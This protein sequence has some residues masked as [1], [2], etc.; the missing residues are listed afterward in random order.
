MKALVVEQ[1]DANSET[2]VLCE[3]RVGDSE[4]VQQ[5]QVV[6][7]V[8]TSKVVFELESPEAG[9]LVQGY[10]AGAEVRFNVP[11]GYIVGSPLEEKMA[12]AA[13]RMS[14]ERPE[15][16][17]Q[18]PKATKKARQLAAQYSVR[19]ED[20]QK[21]GL[22]TERDVQA[23]IA[24]RRKDAPE[25]DLVI[26]EP[27]VMPRGLPRVLVL[28]AGLGAMQVIDILLNDPR[29]QVVGCL[30]D[31]P[32]TH[33]RAIFGVQVWGA[34][35]LLEEAWREGQLDQAIISISTSAGARK[36]LYQR[37]RELGIPL[38]NAIDPTV[39]IN[40]G[41]VIGQ[42]NVIC[43]MVHIGVATVIGDNNFISAHTNI[44]HH[45][46]WGSHNTTGPHCSTSSR[47]VVGDEVVFG[48]GVFMQPGIGIGSG[49]QV[50]SGAVL[51]Q[52]VPPYHAVKSQVSVKIAP[53]ADAELK[54]GVKSP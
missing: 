41:V 18:G 33:G 38:A 17:A 49:C 11:I 40:R 3:W 53:L 43:S 24:E 50:A 14:A 37:C 29:V 51:T 1:I 12:R 47:V 35:A 25:H 54:P 21:P 39:R 16:E 7:V 52:S 8:E 31:D 27:G 2:A 23:V 26:T 6:C 9:R 15:G 36:R 10:S 19:L 5:G 42:G 34:T 4:Q 20:I 45:N 13:L 22:I 30:D 32:Q 48:T 44:D 46:L 28:G